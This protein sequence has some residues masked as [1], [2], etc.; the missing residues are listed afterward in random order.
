MKPHQLS[1]GLPEQAPDFSA[2]SYIVSESNAAAYEA[3]QR[4]LKS[5]EQNLIICGPPSSGKTHL[6]HIIAETAGGI[7]VSGA[8]A[9]GEFADAGALLIIDEFPALAA[10]SDLLSILSKL[11]ASGRRFVLVGEDPPAAW[12]GDLIDLKTRLEATP[13]AVVQEPDE[14]L[15][16]RVIDKLFR[17][18]Q[19]N[20]QPK[21]IKYAAPRLQRTFAAAYAFVALSDEA[22][23]G[24]PG[25]ISLGVAQKIV[26]ALSEHE[27]SA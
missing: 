16:S 4:W 21:V 9:L 7:V 2:A 22:A 8:E 12:A 20:V 3:V 18:R 19:I 17:D 14:A 13:R 27:L 5:E 6:A 15:M 25:G 11:Q 26:A 23:L 1:L 24:K 10:P